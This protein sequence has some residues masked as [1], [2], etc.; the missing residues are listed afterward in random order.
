[1]VDSLDKY[2]VCL[3]DVISSE[4]CDDILEEYE[5]SFDWSKARVGA[6]GEIDTSIRNLSNINMSDPDT[7]ANNIEVRTA[8]DSELFKAVGSALQGYSAKFP[9]C[10]V[11][12]D[13]G[14][15][16]LRYKTGEFYKEHT[17]SFTHEPRVVSCSIA[18]NDEYEGGEF[19]FFGSEVKIRADKGSAIMFPSNFMYPHQIL[20][21]T[22]GVRYSIVT[23]FR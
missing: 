7:K 2:I 21:V 12:L 11:Q 17:D 8:L 13:T 23:W 22:S 18:L 3:K 1:M 10:E 19:A 16:L 14:Y 20:P 6:A 9:R 5:D 15:N 4:L